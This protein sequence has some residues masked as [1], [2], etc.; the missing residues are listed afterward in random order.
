MGANVSA[1]ALPLPAG[2]TATEGQEIVYGIRPECFRPS[3]EGVTGTV[4][5]VEPTGSETH[6]V[7]RVNGRDLTA[8]FRE[9]VSI[10]PGDAI[11]LAP[12]AGAA[13]IFD[14]ASGKRLS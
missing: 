14:K 10:R 11:T 3:A 1:S 8:V 7:V 4:A 5:V 6:V 9:R 12:D 13:H 2:P